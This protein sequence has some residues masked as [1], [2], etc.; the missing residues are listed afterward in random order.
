MSYSILERSVAE[1]L[2]RFPAAKAMLKIAYQAIMYQ[3]FRERQRMWL[4]PGFRI[5]RSLGEQ[6]GS[7]FGYYT[8]LSQSSGGTLW[9]RFNPGLGRSIRSTEKIDIMLD[10]I[11]IGSSQAWNWQQ[12]SMLHWHD[13]DTI[14]WNDFDPNTSRWVTMIY[15]QNT[16]DSVPFATYASSGK[17]GLCVSLDFRRLAH[18][19]PDYGY[20]NLPYQDIPSLSEM[21][22]LWV[23]DVNSATT[24]RFVSI[25]RIA[26]GVFEG[27]PAPLALKL[28][29]AIFS[30][31]GEKIIFLLRWIDHGGAKYSRLMAYESLTD[32]LCEVALERMISHCCWCG[33][34][35]IL[36]WMRG[37]NGDR[38]YKIN[39]DTGEKIVIGEYDLL[40]DG[41][42]SISPCGRW[43][44]TDTYPDRSRMSSLVVYDLHLKRK[45]LLGRFLSP[46]AFHGELRCDLHPRWSEDGSSFSFDS[47][48]EGTRHM[49]VMNFHHELLADG[50]C[51]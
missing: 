19:R 12:G 22:G 5:D 35:S 37:V 42:P 16:L 24:R 41:H 49:Y 4:H 17:S 25:R 3:F 11:K 39:L 9:H 18:F 47:V 34:N 29:H 15:R 30:P 26:D 1:L 36:G 13:A 43:M 48:H 32:S 6:Y 8:L 51:Q 44:L 23:Y 21:D 45:H 10:D 40:E 2:S 46:L 20:F 31:N 38:Y 14:M 27:M 7:F 28:N 33:S 50:E